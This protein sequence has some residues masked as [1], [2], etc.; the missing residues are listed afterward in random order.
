MWGTLATL[1]V[2]AWELS[3]EQ[4]FPIKVKLLSANENTKPTSPMGPTHPGIPS[5]SPTWAVLTYY[6]S[7]LR[8]HMPYTQ[9]M[10][11]ACLPNFF[12]S[13]PRQHLSGGFANSV[14]TM[15]ACRHGATG[16]RP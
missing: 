11:P 3:I 14:R 6:S 1:H 5:A 7:L 10:C 9:G 15:A 8:C 4:G 16:K 12:L 2:A 13:S